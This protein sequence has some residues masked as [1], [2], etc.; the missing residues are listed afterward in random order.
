M[1]WVY[2]FIETVGG[3]LLPGKYALE[4][5]ILRL[6][7]KKKF[8]ASLITPKNSGTDLDI[9]NLEIIGNILAWLVLEE[10]IGTKTSAINTLA[11][12]V[13]KRQKCR[14]HKGGAAKTSAVSGRLLRVLSLQ[15][16]VARAS[17]L[18]AVHMA[19]DLNALGYIP[20]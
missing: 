14:G 11:S 5:T 7:C 13:I 16:L 1:G 2:A 6:E 4:P 20:F 18:L 12:S 19:G 3:G 17:P 8:R 15:Q 10:I 9:N